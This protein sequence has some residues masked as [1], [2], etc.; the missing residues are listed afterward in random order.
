MQPAEENTFLIILLP[1]KSGHLLYPSVEIRAMRSAK[2]EGDEK[3]ADE[4]VRCEVDYLS[5]SESILIV[6]NLS[7]ATVGLD[8]GEAWLVETKSRDGI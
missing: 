2:S 5:Q 4:Q 7:S 6:P 1:Q 8:G 3:A